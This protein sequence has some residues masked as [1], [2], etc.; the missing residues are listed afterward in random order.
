[1]TWIDQLGSVEKSEE[2]AEWAEVR[3]EVIQK[4]KH[5]K[6]QLKSLLDDNITAPESHRLPLLTFRLSTDD[7]ERILESVS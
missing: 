6:Q 2:T 1:M 4:Y 5:I 7:Q 3:L